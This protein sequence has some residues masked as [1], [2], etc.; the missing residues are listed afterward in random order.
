MKTESTTNN[1]LVV[2]DVH[3]GSPVSKVK[4][5]AK[6]LKNEK[7]DHLI[8]NGDL[9]DNKHIE[10]YKKH[11]WNILNI[12]RKIAKKKKVTLI[13]GNHDE[14]SRAIIKILG[15]DFVDEYSMEINGKRMLFIHYHQFDSFIKKYPIITTIAENVYYFIQKIDR[16]KKLSRWL[17]RT[18]KLFL[19]VKLR[20]RYMAIDYIT[21]KPYDAIFGGHIHYAECY[22]C[23]KTKKE[24]YNSGSFCDE[25]CHYLLINDKGNVTLKEI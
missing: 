15:L 14:N 8:V 9:F 19:Q 22:T 23:P 5:F 12:I 1:I 20:I 3:L 7:Y 25:P 13:K 2:S 16:S 4:S 6:L 18:S 11:H 17:K 21:D 24:Y 10:R